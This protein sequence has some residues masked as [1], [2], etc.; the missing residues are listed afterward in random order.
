MRFLTQKT[1][2]KIDILLMDPTIGGF[3]IYQLMELAGLSVA[4]AICK[5]YPR[6]KYPRI[7][8]V[9]G[10]GNNG[11]DALVAAR[12]LTHFGFKP[13]ILYPKRP[14]KEL[15]LGLV[16]QCE[17]LR[18]PFLETWDQGLMN[19]EAGGVD[20]ILDGVFGFSFAGEVR[21]PFKEILEKLKTLQETTGTPIVSIDI[22]SGWDVERGPEHFDTLK[23]DMLISLTAPKLCAKYFRGKHHWVGGRFVPKSLEEMVDGL[24]VPVYPEDGSQCVEVRLEN[25][26]AMM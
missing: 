8:V 22:P 9:A 20:L 19:S 14:Q 1:A 18:I 2:Q 12:H 15:F 6:D 21:A 10:P 24:E 5:V 26:E 17:N 23:P 3:S 7:L 16:K 4:Q 11:G 13:S 25:Q